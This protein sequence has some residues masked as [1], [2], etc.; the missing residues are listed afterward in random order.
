M[1]QIRHLTQTENTGAI[2]FYFTLLTTVIGFASIGMGWKMPTAWQWTLLIGTGLIGGTAQI[3]VT[4][5]LRYAEASLLAP[6]DYDDDLGA[7]DWLC[8]HGSGAGA[9]D[10]SGGFYRGCRRFVHVVAG[11][12]AAQKARHGTVDAVGSLIDR[13]ASRFSRHMANSP[14]AMTVS[15]PTMVAP[16]GTSAMKR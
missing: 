15:A 1:I 7:V 11:K 3:L 2:I 8:P 14:A 10:H 9:D 6:F 16:V 12:A 4:L 5:S 13:F